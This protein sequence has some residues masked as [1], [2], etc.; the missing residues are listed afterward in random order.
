VLGLLAVITGALEE[1]T[2]TVLLHQPLLQLDRARAEFAVGSQHHGQ[3]QGSH[4]APT[5]EKL[6]LSDGGQ[7]G[8]AIDFD[9]VFLQ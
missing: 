6:L 1:E 7:Q 5:V 3:H 8:I 4:G 2:E 9:L